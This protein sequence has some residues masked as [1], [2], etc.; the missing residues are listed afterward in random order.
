MI[1]GSNLLAMALRVITPTTVTYYKWLSRT[2]NAKGML[3]NNYDQGRPIRGSFQP[4]P[5]TL[6]Q[7]LELDFSKK[8]YMLYTV[9]PILEVDRDTSS[10]QIGFNGQRFQVVSNNDWHAIDGWNGVMTVLI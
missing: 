5:Q 4:V 1:P 8:Y 9:E 6:Y 7:Q 10:D 2:G 3:V